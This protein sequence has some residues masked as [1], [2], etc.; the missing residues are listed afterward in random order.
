M[1]FLSLVA[2]FAAFVFVG[3]ASLGFGPQP[4]TPRTLGEELAAERWRECRHV[5]G[6]RFKEIRAGDLWVEYNGDEALSAWRDCHTKALY[7]QINRA[8]A[9][10]KRLPGAAGTAQVASWRP[11]MEWAFW[12]KGP[13]GEG[14]YVWAVDRET[15]LEGT[16]CYVLRTGNRE[17]F[18]RKSDL[19]LVGETL[20]GQ[21]EMLWTPPRSGF[22]WP[23]TI[24]RAWEENVLELN[25][26]DGTRRRHT[27]VGSVEGEEMVSVPAATVR[28]IKV[29]VRVKDTATPLVEAWYAPELAQVV[30][31][32][33]HLSSGLRQRELFAYRL[34]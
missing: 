8:K 29:V 18:A 10:A 5:S 23:L 3:C 20:G 33:E 21:L 30:L 4:P 6:V 14:A 32:R 22:V 19:A 27:F 28:A 24:G 9:S 1:A 16:E 25:L 7:A 17:I 2:V 26:K 13:D 34:Q 31:L 12:W 11:G 15:D